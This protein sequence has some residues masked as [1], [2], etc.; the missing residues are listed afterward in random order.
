MKA[1]RKFEIIA[2]MFMLA[3]SAF[4]YANQAPKDAQ[5]DECDYVNLEQCD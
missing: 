5:F 3:N 1:K 4:A 2:I